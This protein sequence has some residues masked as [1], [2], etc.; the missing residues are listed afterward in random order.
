MDY[1]GKTAIVTGGTKGI[2]RAIAEALAEEGMNVCVGA[3]NLDEV[4]Q[5]VRELEG[6]GAQASGAA[7]DVRVYEEV[8]ALV[9]HAVEEFGGVDVLVNNAGIGLHKL[10]EETS[11]EEFRAVLETNLFGVFYGC[12]AAIPEM[13][14]RGGGYIIN[15]SSLAGAN[16]HP[17]MAAYNASKFALNG[18]SEA[19]MQE[20]RHDRIKVSYVMPGS[21]N[22]EFGGGNVSEENAWQLQSED[23]ARVV[24]DLLRHDRRSLPSRVEIRPSMPPKK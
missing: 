18:F 10:V 13:K 24:V 7:C 3:R 1:K 6:T 23:I 16:P 19:L 5:T 2:G 20:V 8:E 22:T 11:P 21:V 9:A 15:I 12:R 14:K 17:R 4:K